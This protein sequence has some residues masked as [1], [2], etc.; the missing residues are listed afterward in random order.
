MG[1]FN[2][3]KNQEREVINQV[4]ESHGEGDETMSSRSCWDAGVMGWYVHQP[5][6]GPKT[7][8]CCIQCGALDENAGLAVCQGCNVV[9][10]CRKCR[11]SASRYG[12]AVVGSLGYG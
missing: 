5:L 7:L 6:S 4:S 9:H 2:E 1:H 11:R 8:P 3:E 12:H 10:F